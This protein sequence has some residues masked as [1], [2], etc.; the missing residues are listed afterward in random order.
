MQIP[1]S[2]VAFI[3]ALLL[4]T[5]A[6]ALAG[7]VLGVAL[8]VRIMDPP[9]IGSTNGRTDQRSVGTEGSGQDA[10]GHGW[11]QAGLHQAQHRTSE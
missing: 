9:R 1:I 3:L 6:A 8:P 4:V 10:N 7:G 5:A 11:E 2:A